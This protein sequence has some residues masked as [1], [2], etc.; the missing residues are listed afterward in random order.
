[1]R[2]SSPTRT[3]SRSCRDGSSAAA[4]VL[5]VD[6]TDDLAVIKVDKTGLT[7]AARQVVGPENR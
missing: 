6:R 3:R 2:T 7:A 4:K 1:M 5:G